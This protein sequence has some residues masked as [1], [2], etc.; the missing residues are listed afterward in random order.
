M[1]EWISCKDR[2]PKEKILVMAM[3]TVIQSPS[4]LDGID[5]LGKM[6]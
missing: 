5:E 1:D 6:S 3:N 4:W 2:L